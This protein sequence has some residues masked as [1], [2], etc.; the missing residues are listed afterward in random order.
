MC[1]DSFSAAFAHVNESHFVYPRGEVPTNMGDVG[2]SSSGE[3]LGDSSL[4]QHVV[5]PPV[6]VTVGAGGPLSPTMA[7]AIERDELRREED[8]IIVLS[9]WGC[10]WLK[11]AFDYI[12][13]GDRANQLATHMLKEFDATNED[14]SVYLQTH[15]L[16]EVKT[17][18]TK[19]E[20]T[21]KQQV[22][23]SR[24]LRRVEKLAKGR[25]S[26]FAVAVAKVAYNKFG[27]RPLSEAN[28]LVTRKWIQKY[29]EE[30]FKDLRVCD[31]NLAIDRALFL[32]FVPTKDFH[33]CRLM[34]MS[35]VMESRLNG[36]SAFGR[37][38]RIR[39]DFPE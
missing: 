39:S 18:I 22:V 32:S 8:P 21:G 23:D 20:K 36:K 3:Y 10:K 24:R 19:D 12:V 33:K 5:D 28:L 17:E 6:D 27:Q 2:A 37:I 34:M 35:S 11:F 15:V 7:R 31:K 1:D 4:P 29:L 38:F 13:K 26:R 16:E 25:R 9:R 14:P 30:T